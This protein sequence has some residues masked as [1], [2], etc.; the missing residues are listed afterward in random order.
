LAEQ[1]RVVRRVIKA[2][3]DLLDHKDYK[4]HLV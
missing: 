4:E 1:D 3:P 2:I